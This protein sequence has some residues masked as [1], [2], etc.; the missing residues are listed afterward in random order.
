MA[1]GEAQGTAFEKQLEALRAEVQQGFQSVQQNHATLAQG[2]HY[3]AEK[4]GVLERAA[5]ESRKPA[6][7]PIPSD[8]NERMRREQWENPV[9]VAAQTIQIAKDQAVNE[10]RAL[11]HAEREQAAREEAW[12]NA[13]DHFFYQN[14]DIDR[15]HEPTVQKLVELVPAQVTD[16]GQRQAQAAQWLRERLASQYATMQE[17]EKRRSDGAQAVSTGGA[18]Q[19]YMGILNPAGAGQSQA[20]ARDDYVAR[21]K[22]RLEVIQGR[23]KAA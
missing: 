16:Y 6:P 3:V 14:P 4:T 12:R 10:T 8:A 21:R 15:I 11:L 5:V 18:A 22:A 17:Q 20:Q 1:E 19:D 13:W 9:G 2:V 7:P 23:G